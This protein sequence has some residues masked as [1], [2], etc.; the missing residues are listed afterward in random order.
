MGSIAIV[1]V[2]TLSFAGANL[3]AQLAALET[4]RRRGI[5]MRPAPA[6]ALEH[7]FS[8]HIDGMPR[9]GADRRDLQ[10]AIG[11]DFAAQDIEQ[12]VWPRDRAH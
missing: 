4:T 2:I 10:R 5:P 8:S 12:S 3:F 6:V 11:R 9:A 1:V 7:P